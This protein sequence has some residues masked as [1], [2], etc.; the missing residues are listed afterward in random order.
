MMRRGAHRRG[1]TLIE[2]IIALGLG[3]VLVL[4]AAT[5]LRMAS[6]TTT[7]ATR[8][9]LEN[10]LMRSAFLR[11]HEELDFWRA[12]DDPENAA[13]RPYRDLGEPFAPMT[14]AFPRGTVATGN[15]IA[16]PREFE[17]GWDE[18][19]RWPAN[20]KRTWMRANL[21]EKHITALAFGRYTLF[22]NTEPQLAVNSSV[23]AYGTVPVPHS[24]LATQYYGMQDRLGYYAFADYMPADALFA[25]S[26]PYAGAGSDRERTNAGGMTMR[27][28]APGTQF[29]PGEGTTEVVK[30][31]WRLTMPAAYAIPK[32]GAA[33]HAEYFR[34][35]Y[36]NTSGS[37]VQRL[38]DRA[39][40][41][42][43]L[44]PLK[45]SAWPAATYSVMRFIKTRRFVNLSTLGFIS[46]VTGE[47]IEL[48]FAG[49]GTTLRG[50][51]QQRHPVSGW[52][53]YDNASV[54]APGTNLDTS[55]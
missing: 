2:M 50:A 8:L 30:S 32:P 4:T 34:V 12:Y 10:T 18:N 39:R 53:D 5:G 19:Y 22:W 1:F 33:G 21:A 49:Y 14:A 40:I 13:N 45:P 36:Q 9:S 7:A 6:Q 16:D 42:Q 24:W 25:T 55:P 52:V 35:G 29:E 48:S 23:G 15:A 38:A 3:L 37:E 51:R 28:V 44:M 17:V 26:R 43:R 47:R 11:A 54:P 27:L 31:L 20:D 41:D 46:P